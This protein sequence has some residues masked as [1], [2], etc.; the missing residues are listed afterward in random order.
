MSFPDLQSR[1]AALFERAR[2]VMP[3]ANTR[4]MITFGPYI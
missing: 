4:H 3:G 1:S 2:H